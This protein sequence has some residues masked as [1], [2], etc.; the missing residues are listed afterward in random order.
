[1]ADYMWPLWPVVEIQASHSCTEVHNPYG[2]TVSMRQLDIILVLFSGVSQP[3]T[4]E[5]SL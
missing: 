5:K 1:M 3:A 2:N 4:M